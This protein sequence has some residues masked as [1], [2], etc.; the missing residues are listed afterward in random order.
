MKGKRTRCHQ[1][2][3]KG[4]EENHRCGN[5]PQGPEG[6]AGAGGSSS[7]PLHVLRQVTELLWGSSPPLEGQ[8]EA[9]TQQGSGSG[10]EAVIKQP[11]YL[12][13]HMC[14]AGSVPCCCCYIT[15]FSSLKRNMSVQEFGKE[16]NINQKNFHNS[17]MVPTHRGNLVFCY[18]S[19]LSP[20]LLISYL[21]IIIQGCHA[22]QSFFIP[23]SM[24]FEHLFT[25]SHDLLFHYIL[26]YISLHCCD[27]S[28]LNNFPSGNTAIGHLKFSVIRNKPEITA[29][30]C[31]YFH[32]SLTESIQ[33][34]PYN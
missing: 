19:F 25:L 3:K 13:T 6:R 15:F 21:F 34:E 31:H 29:C 20:S 32:F 30:R 16:V 33:Y 8:D 26:G 10:Q 18:F 23:R 22:P 1:H 28:Q 9:A 2:N 11:V 17:L 14:M 27:I 7:H 4:R 12:L 24:Y 5:S